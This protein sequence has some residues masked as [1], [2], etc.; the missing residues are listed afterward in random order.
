MLGLLQLLLTMMMMM[1][2]MIRRGV[3]QWGWRVL[4]L[5]RTRWRQT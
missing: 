4:G 2:M 1:M 5:L 3:M